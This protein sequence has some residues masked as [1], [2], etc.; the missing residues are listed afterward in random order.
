M[1]DFFVFQIQLFLCVFF[2]SYLT[3]SK[4]MLYNEHK[5]FFNKYDHG[6][7]MSLQNLYAE[8]LTTKS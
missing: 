7:F 4:T 3:F 6:L 1:T 2:P 8:I 5:T